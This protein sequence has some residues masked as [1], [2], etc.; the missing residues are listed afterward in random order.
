MNVQREHDQ[1][2]QSAD[3]VGD[4]SIK[5]RSAAMRLW[6][7][8]VAATLGVTLALIAGHHIKRTVAASEK[9]ENPEV[10]HGRY[11]A[12]IGGCH[13][14]HTPGY[15]T[16]SGDVP[17]ESLL[18][19]D[20]V[21]FNGPWGTT[22]PVNL[23]RYMGSITEDGWVQIARNMKARPPMPWF[24]LRAMSDGDLR[25]LYRYIRSLPANDNAAPDYVPPD[26]KPRTPYIVFVPQQP[27]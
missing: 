19:G 2:A 22:Y 1:A 3:A 23:R 21:G 10:A 18:V 25:A 27:T 11:L 20:A 6:T 16:K 17:E 14:C 12:R 9:V 13:D 15:A 5:Q 24:N 7:K 8:G 26:G 4:C